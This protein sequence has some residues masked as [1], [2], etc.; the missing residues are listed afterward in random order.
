MRQI[1]KCKS[2]FERGKFRHFNELTKIFAFPF[3]LCLLPSI[4]P[5]LFKRVLVSDAEAQHIIDG[6]DNDGDGFL[7]FDEYIEVVNEFVTDKMT[8]DDMLAAFKHMDADGNGHI[9]KEELKDFMKKA[10]QRIS[11]KELKQMMKDADKND[12]GKVNYQEF[13]RM[14]AN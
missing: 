9:T 8:R 1:G 3:L 5:R 6:L 2:R 14:V 11:K 10:G 4:T 7:Q 13:L 12:D